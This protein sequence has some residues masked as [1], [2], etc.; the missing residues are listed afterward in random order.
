M[1]VVGQLILLAILHLVC[2]VSITIVYRRELIKN[3]WVSEQT[4]MEPPSMENTVKTWAWIIL[5]FSVPILQT[6]ALGI[7]IYACFNKYEE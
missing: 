2:A 5:V 1:T 3:G 6:I 7:L 4:H